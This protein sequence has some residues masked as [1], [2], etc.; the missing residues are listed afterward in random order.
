[1][2]PTRPFRFL[3]NR[4]HGTPGVVVLPDGHFRRAKEEIASWPGYA[5]TPLVD[6]P[7]VAEA[8][9]VGSVRY[10]DEGGRFGLGSFKALGG[11]YAV[12]RLL[13]AELARRG[14]AN[15]ATAA[16]LMEGKFKDATRAI[17][18]TCATDG[19]HCRSVAGSRAITMTRLRRP[20]AWQRR[21]AGS[22]SRIPPGLAT[23]TFPASS[24]RATPSWCARRWRPC[25][26]LRHTLSP[27]GSLKS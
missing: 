7:D 4:Q 17:T 19:N 11:A 15:A 12:M 25:L 22:F 8:A 14:A 3:V 24:C 16:E 5:P 23:S 20:P 21:K 2:I 26:S 10:K 18:V 27:N 13:Q 1:M 9:R 6:L